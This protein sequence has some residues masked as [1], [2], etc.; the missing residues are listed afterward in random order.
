MRIA[1]LTFHRAYNCGA[2]LQAWALK[3]VLERMG[4]EVEFPVNHVGDAGCPFKFVR[5]IPLGKKGLDLIRSFAGRFVMDVMALFKAKP[6]GVHQFA[7]FRMRHF[8]ERK[9]KAGRFKDYYDLVIVG[10]DQVWNFGLAG[11]FSKWFLGEDV[12]REVPMIAYA[13]S[14]G[15]E[16]LTLENLR[17]AR[18]A[19]SRFRAVSVREPVLRDQLFDGS[20][21]EIV[22]TIDPSLLV[23]ANCYSCLY[24]A[25]ACAAP[26][27]YLYTLFATDYEIGLARELARRLGL[28]LHISV[29]CRKPGDSEDVDIERGVTPDRMVSQ[30]AHAEYVLAGSFHGTALS[31]VHRKR[32]LSLRPRV[33]GRESR[34]EALLKRLNLHK[35]LVNPTVSIDECFARLC[36]SYP[37]RFEADLRQYVSSSNDWLEK[38]VNYAEK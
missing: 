20:G 2:M 16:A 11:R 35:R 23:S 5:S 30:I 24:Q 33:D 26:Y 6:L 25:Q 4:H 34:P 38:A 18:E 28:H 36:E 19:L 29:V 17:R 8:V 12:P 3:T 37:A 1:I 21:R 15:D 32:F 31:I 13:A 10:S 14:C 22:V 7:A 9:C 27:V